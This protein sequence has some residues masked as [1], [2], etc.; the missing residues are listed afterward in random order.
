MFRE[1]GLE[2]KG[3]K[4]DYEELLMPYI[5]ILLSAYTNILWLVGS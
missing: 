1:D 3:N 4:A 2:L 5:P